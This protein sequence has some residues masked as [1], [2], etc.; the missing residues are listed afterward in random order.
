MY[1]LAVAYPFL[2]PASTPFILMSD[3]ISNNQ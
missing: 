3:A 2:V 1:E